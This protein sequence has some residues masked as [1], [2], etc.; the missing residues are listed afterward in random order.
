MPR[1]TKPTQL[2][3]SPWSIAAGTSPCE[4]DATPPPPTAA[5]SL[6]WQ[7]CLAHPLPEPAATQDY[8]RSRRTPLCCR[9]WP[10]SPF[11]GLLR[12]RRRWTAAMP[13]STRRKKQQLCD[14][15]SKELWL[16]VTLAA[17]YMSFLK[18]TNLLLFQNLLIYYYHQFYFVSAQQLCK[19]KFNIYFKNHSCR[20][21]VAF[22]I[23]TSSAACMDCVR[24]H[25]GY[26]SGFCT[27]LCS[28]LLSSVP[29]T[30]YPCT[31]SAVCCC[32]LSTG[33]GNVRGRRR[34]YLVHSLYHRVLCREWGG[35]FTLWTRVPPRLYPRCSS[36]S[37]ALSP[38]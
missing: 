16:R 18:F 22:T 1:S 28:L 21:W 30:L 31:V 13:C 8:Y 12:H 14:K 32:F 27:D 19:I 34:A 33:G 37:S 38:M 36:G 26:R 5:A 20:I 2:P 35:S 15:I 10:L 3:R 7:R 11:H 6:V 23:R 24:L 17:K 29:F 4:C 9:N 25:Y